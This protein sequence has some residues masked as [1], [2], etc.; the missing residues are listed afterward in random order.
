ME[1]E[2]WKFVNGYEGLYLVSTYGRVMSLNYGNTGNVRILKQSVK[3]GH[4]LKVTLRDRDGNPKTFRVHRLVAE[5]FLPKPKPE[6]TQVDHI[7][8][9]KT[10]NRKEN[11]RWSSPRENTN[12]P[13]TKGNYHNRYHKEG[14]FERR[15]AGQKLRFQ[16]PEERER[17]LRVSKKGLDAIARNRG[18]RLQGRV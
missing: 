9:I 8:G 4:Y 16:H 10:D 17:I 7:N 13:A 18:N 15:S 3:A 6:Q 14:E 12:N 2:E 5:A 1:L 11:L